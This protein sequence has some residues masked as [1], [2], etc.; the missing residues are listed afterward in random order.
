MKI[1]VTQIS[2]VSP[3]LFLFLSDISK[4]FQPVQYHSSLNGNISLRSGW[5]ILIFD[6]GINIQ[7]R[8][9]KFRLMFFFVCD[10]VGPMMHKLVQNCRRRCETRSAYVENTF[11]LRCLK[12]HKTNSLKFN[13]NC[14]REIF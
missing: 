1:E 7:E 5:I 2:C 10:L 11:M 9:K 12:Y 4:C 6:I 8:K 13:R 14:C 3:I